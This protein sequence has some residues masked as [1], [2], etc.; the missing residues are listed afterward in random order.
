MLKSHY[1]TELKPISPMPYKSVKTIAPMRYLSLLAAT[2]VFSTIFQLEK[3]QAQDPQ[4][5]Q[6]Y[7][8]QQESSVVDSE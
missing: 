4:F 7:A 2:I 3:V 5:S 8:A 6:F 1:L